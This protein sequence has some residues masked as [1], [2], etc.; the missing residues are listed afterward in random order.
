MT[1]P[2]VIIP[3]VATTLKSD[4]MT[5]VTEPTKSSDSTQSSKKRKR[6]TDALEE[7]QVDVNAPEPP[8]KKALR[9]AKKGKSTIDGNITISSATPLSPTHDEEKAAPVA[10]AEVPETSHEASSKRSPHGIWIGNLPFTVTKSDLQ[11]FLT[12]T[13]DITESMITRVH[14]PPPSDA[15]TARQKIKSQNRGFAYVDFSTPEAVAKALALSETL[16][17][18]RRVLIKDAHNF[19][20]R[21]EKTADSIQDATTGKISG[22]PPSKRIFVGNLTFDAEKADLE[23]HFS[24]CGEVV[25]VHVA[26]FEDSGKCKGYAW[27]TF[28]E[29]E[30]AEAAVRGWVMKPSE[31]AGEQEEKQNGEDHEVEPSDE[32]ASKPKK[33][34]PKDRKWWVNKLK[35]RQ[36]RMEFAEDPSVRYKKRFGKDGT[37]TNDKSTKE[38]ELAQPDAPIEAPAVGK[39]VRPIRPQ[40]KVDARTVKPGAALAAAPRLTGGIVPSQGKKISFE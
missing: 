28:G 4:G 39:T 25:D 17:T 14:M 27:I 30:E 9:R 29:L 20:G 11:A 22:K 6:T 33:K 36:L 38:V 31:E 12:N 35:G 34:L 23:E 5:P 3:L 16:L 15:S 13:P 32:K 18:G 26:T 8:S 7:L 40:R 24:Q 19:E 37:R 1:V 21:P 2:N 10:P